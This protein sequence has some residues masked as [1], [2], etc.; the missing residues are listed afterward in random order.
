MALLPLLIFSSLSEDNGYY[1]ELRKLPDFGRNI[2]NK[3]ENIG[4]VLGQN[5]DINKFSILSNFP[6]FGLAREIKL[7][8][9]EMTLSWADCFNTLDFRHG[10]RAVV[11]RNSLIIL[12]LSDKA[13]SY[14]LNL[15]RELKEMGAKL[16]VFGDIVPKEFYNLTDDIIEIGEKISEWLRGILFLPVIHFLAYYKAV[17][18]GLNPDKPKNLTYFVEIK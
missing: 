5:E 4:K 10:P 12:F 3:Y 2:I 1:E 17:K 15:A 14:E 6:N 13:V 11:D 8:I 18:K 7:K 9:L 16:L